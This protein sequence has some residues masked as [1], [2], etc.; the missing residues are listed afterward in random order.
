MDGD[1]RSEDVCYEGQPT[2]PPGSNV[3]LASWVRV[4]PSYFTTIGT[5]LLQGRVFFAATP[6][7]AQTWPLWMRLSS[8]YYLHG[9]NAVGAH[10]GD[11][12]ASTSGMYTIVG[13]GENAQYW[14]AND[15]QERVIRCTSFR[16]AVGGTARHHGGR[17]RCTRS[18]LPRRT[19]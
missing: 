16:L 6:A 2:P 15:P 11:W 13:V 12:D 1:T 4:S 7:M 5:K 3:N 17:G 18:S 9:Q 8:R 10:F 14:P 19:I